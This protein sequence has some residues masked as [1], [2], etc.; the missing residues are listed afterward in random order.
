VKLSQIEG[1]WDRR[2]IKAPGHED[3]TTR[4]HWT[5]SGLTYADVRVPLE[6]PDLSGASC[7]ADLP[8]EALAQLAK[9][10]GFAGHITLEGIRCTWHREVNWHGDPDW[11]GIGDV[12]DL[13]FEPNGDMIET[14]VEAEYTELWTHRTAPKQSALEFGN[15]TYRG[16]LVTVSSEFVLGIGKPNHPATK[17]L[18]DELENGTIPNGI[19]ALFST[20]HAYGHWDGDNAIANLATNPFCEGKPVLT[21]SGKSVTWRHIGFDGTLSAIDLPIDQ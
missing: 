3:H 18:L 8:V 14:G 16:Y 20:F 4:V 2:W 5:Q 15:D 1:H 6:R 19:D 11:T 12:G 13:T 9:A 7:L 17:T 21:K 10:E